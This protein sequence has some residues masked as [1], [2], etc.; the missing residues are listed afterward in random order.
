LEHL[1]LADNQIS[2]ISAL[3]GLRDLEYL[4]LMNNPVSDYTPVDFVPLVYH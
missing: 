1:H 2:D 4:D 3:S